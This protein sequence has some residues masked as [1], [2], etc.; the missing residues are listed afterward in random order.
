MT[1]PIHLFTLS[2]LVLSLSACSTMMP[3]PALDGAMILAEPNLPLTLPYAIDKSDGE[4][5]SDD[6]TPSIAATGWQQFYDDDK[7]KALIALGLENNKDLEAATL[8]IQRAAA[9]YQITDLSRL[10]MVGS[11]VSYTRQG[12]KETSN[13]A[14]RVGLGL[15]SY[16]LDLWGKIASQKE[17]ALQNYL[18]TNAAKDSVQIALIANIA[19]QYV[20][21]SYAKAQLYLAESTVA[22][23]E[24]SLY[25]TQK[26]FEAGVDSKSPS[27]QAQSSLEGARLSVLAAKAA[28][29]KTQNALSFLIG[30][31]VPSELMPEPAVVK[32][33]NTQVFYTG[34]PSELL[35]YRPDIAAAEY[36]LKAAGANIAM[37]RSAFFPSIQLSGNLGLSSVSLDNLFKSGSFGWSFGPSV[38]L[39][40]FDA[41]ARRANYEVAK[42]EQQQALT[43][44]EQSIQTAFREV[45]DVLAERSV[46]DEQLKIQ[47]RLQENFQQTYNIAYATFRTGLANYLDVLEAERG[48]FNA[49]QNI[50]DI[51]KAKVL[52]QISLYQVLGGGASLTAEP[53]TH[54]QQQAVAM[55]V[56]ELANEEQV[57]VLQSQ[58]SPASLKQAWARHFGDDKLLADGDVLNVVSSK[59]GMLIQP[60]TVQTVD[61]QVNEVENQQNQTQDKIQPTQP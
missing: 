51:E 38:N 61:G 45:H 35:H 58:R 50:L 44:Y 33:V 47:Y 6:N 49:Q 29:L 17:Q 40:I 41:G 59:E 23:R 11:S 53:I 54:E 19:R 32:V 24:R 7:L 8:A 20:N 48:L 9:Q 37:A 42:V 21:L 12:N 13:D 56:P 26:R 4:T 46:L 10:P 16:E 57:A 2:A 25:I 36:R 43:A 52:S 22:S 60:D 34:L 31:A 3:P 39:P 5:V 55:A 27:L 28:V 14:Y 15:S 18:A 30:G 1:K